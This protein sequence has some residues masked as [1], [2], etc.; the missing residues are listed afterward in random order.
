MSDKNICSVHWVDENILEDL[1]EGLEGEEDIYDLSNMFKALSDPTRLNILS[2]LAKSELCVCDIASI[3]GSSQ[4]SI[5]HHLRTLRN[6]RLVKFRKEGKQ[7]IYTVDDDHVH[8]LFV[9]GLNHIQH[10]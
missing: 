8:E 7:V 6:T 10:K 3:L 1:R 5:S 4:S 2:L 9:Q